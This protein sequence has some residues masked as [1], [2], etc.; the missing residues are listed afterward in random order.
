MS[1]TINVSSSWKYVQQTY[2]N[3]NNNWKAIRHIYVKFNNTWNPLYS[4]SWYTGNW[5]DC[6][7]SCGGGTQTRQVN[8]TRNH[9]GQTG[10][11]GDW[12]DVSDSFCTA[13][14]LTKP[15]TSQVC[16]THSCE[17]LCRYDSE[18]ESTLSFGMDTYDRNGLLAITMMWD[19]VVITK[20]N[21]LASSIIY[22]GYR[23]YLGELM[24]T[25]PVTGGFT[26][27]TYQVCRE[28]I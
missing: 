9:S 10:H 6:S 17:K 1:L 2:V 4:Y 23:Y 5:S 16:N 8:C 25:T 12:K 26:I 3:V 20:E 19:G 28:S 13:S 22:N 27:H 11:V 18:S 14:G 24:T 15:S 21:N 7:V